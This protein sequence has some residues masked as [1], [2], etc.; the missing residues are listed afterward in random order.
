MANNEL[1]GPVVVTWLARWVAQCPRRYTYRFVFLPETI[2]SI[3]YLSCNLAHLKAHT[4][5]GFVV[6]CV[7]DDRAHSYLPSRH[8]TTLA[9]RVALHTLRH[10]APRFR[11]YSFLDRGSDE[12][13][14][15]AP[16]V[17]LPVCSVMR[18]KYGDYPEYHTSLDDLTLVTPSGLAGGFRA[19]VRCLEC[20]EGNRTYRTTV[21]GEPQLG[22]R[23]LYPTISSRGSADHVATM[24]HLLAYADGSHDLLSIADIIGVPM[25]DLLPIVDS[26]SQHGLLAEMHVDA[27]SM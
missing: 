21:V 5:A 1:S 27:H 3:A 19:L 14:Y 12:R 26:L 17:D 9:D 18:S 10:V 23:G 11:R 16:G 7:G 22:K 13:Q 8:G 15:C 24:M 6:T 4:A 2:G 20:L 25:W